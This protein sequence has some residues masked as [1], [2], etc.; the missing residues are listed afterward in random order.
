MSEEEKQPWLSIITV[1][2]D[3][4]SGFEQTRLSILKQSLKNFEWV[5]VDSSKV[6]LS[7]Q[8]SDVYAWTEPN[9]VF[10]AMNVGLQICTGQRVL[11]LNAGDALNDKETLA[12]IHLV[13]SNMDQSAVHFGDVAFVSADGLETVTPPPFDFVLERARQFSA[14]RF[15]P[16]Q[17]VIAPRKALIDLG[18]FDE[19]YKVAGDYKTTLLLAERTAF[20]YLPLVITR[21]TLGGVSSQNWLAG[22]REF[23]RARVEVYHLSGLSRVRSGWSS[24]LQL[25]KMAA[26]RSRHKLRA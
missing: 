21:F 6:K 15:P 5:V 2:K 19:S 7:D 1:V 17:G 10:P 11:F 4:L 8:D 3:D 25:L 14:G 22:L 12:E 23:H 18:G 13:S 24:S 16:H 20:N 26:V 9:G